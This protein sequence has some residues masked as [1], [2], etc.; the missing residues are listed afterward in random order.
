MNIF[1]DHFNIKTLLLIGLIDFPMC[2]TIFLLPDQYSDL[3]EHL[4]QLQIYG[5]CGSVYWMFQRVTQI[6]PTGLWALMA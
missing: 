6:L 3:H 2:N 1:S 4:F 5:C